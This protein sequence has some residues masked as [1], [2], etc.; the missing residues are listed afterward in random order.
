MECSFDDVYDGGCPNGI[1]GDM[2]SALDLELSQLELWR[3]DP[4]DWPDPLY[5]G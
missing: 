3:D 4:S 1:G 2:V 5:N